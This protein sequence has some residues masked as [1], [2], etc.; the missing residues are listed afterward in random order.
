MDGSINV[1]YFSERWWE[2]FAGSVLISW[3]VGVFP[4]LN[5]IDDKI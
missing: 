2:N 1:K 3:F 5:G 4:V